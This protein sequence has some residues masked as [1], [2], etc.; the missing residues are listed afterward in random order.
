MSKEL[1]TLGYRQDGTPIKEPEPGF[2]YTAAL[3]HCTKCKKVISGCG[4]PAF[5][6]NCI[7]CAKS[8]GHE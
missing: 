1:K 6:S 5:G 4:G 3:I 8:D 7:D 2:F